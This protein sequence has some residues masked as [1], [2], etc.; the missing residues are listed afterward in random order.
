MHSVN[1]IVDIWCSSH[2]QTKYTEYPWNLEINR[3]ATYM[4]YTGLN[5]D[6]IRDKH[7]TTGI[8][9]NGFVNVWFISWK[10]I[11]LDYVSK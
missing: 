11:F 8:N 10:E 1:N 6:V 9:R 7:I 3:Q 5:M 2:E 4:L